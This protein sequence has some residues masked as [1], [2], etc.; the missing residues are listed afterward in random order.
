MPKS[1]KV[2]IKRY[3]ITMK[4]ILPY[5]CVLIALTT[6]CK[7]NASTNYE[8]NKKRILIT[9]IPQKFIIEN[10]LPTDSILCTVLVPKG[11]SPATYDLSASQIKEISGARAWL[12]IGNLGFENRW[13]KSMG[14]NNDKLLIFNTSE[15]IELI[16]GEEVEHGDHIHEGGVDP[17]VWMSAKEMKT[18][19]KNSA[20]ALSEIFPDKK[21]DIYKNLDSLLAIIHDTDKR[22]SIILKDAPNNNFM[23][24]HPALTYFARQYGFEQ[25]PMEVDG[26]SPSAK[27]LKSLI[28]EAKSKGIS[29]IFVQEEFDK[30]NA[31]TLAKET[32]AKVVNIE[33]LSDKWDENIIS[34]AKHLAK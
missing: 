1:L 16:R 13:A 26:K 33:I 14:D 17:H 28:D 18:L 21:S 7:P 3:K 30:H 34:I 29:I 2:Q 6:S 12:Q 9:I 24:Y 8:D 20:C 27:Q 19:A 22:L 25:H 11:A 32:G 10:L 15:G 23:I 31:K 4:Y 5:F